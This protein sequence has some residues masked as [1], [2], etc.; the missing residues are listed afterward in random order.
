[1]GTLSFWA[2][3]DGSTANNAALNVENTVTQPTTEITFDSGATGDLHLESNGGLADPDTTVWIDGI[4][5]DFI[6][7]QIGTLPVSPRVPDEYENLEVVVI[8]VVIDGT[9]ERLFFVSDGSGTFAGMEAFGSGA[10][11]LTGVTE[12]PPVVYI[13]FCTGTDIL[14]D[15]GYKKIETLQAGDLVQT[16][17][18]K[19]SPILWIGNSPTTVGEMQRDVTRRPIRIPA[20]AI[21]PGAP[22]ADL[23]VS[24]QH[25]IVL[26][27]CWSQMY[28]GEESVMLPAKHLVGLAAERVMPSEDINY[29]HILLE[30][31][32]VVISNELKTE[33]FQPS[34]RSFNGI[35][36]EMRD[37]LS[38]TIPLDRLRSI[39]RRPDAMRS[40]KRLESNVL[41]ERMFASNQPAPKTISNVG[42]VA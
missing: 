27:G 28:F 39:F 30:D 21:A 26:E 29:Y 20:N 24:A 15:T 32:E 18:G 8:S 17:S 33:S 1:M 41:A 11:A 35:S 6:L 22:N 7:E 31:H 5:Y 13:C 4:E 40:L 14:T 16:E 37:S 23:Y 34:L 12:D 38:E 2:R 9:Y 42:N 10:V 36:Q 25:R 3:G 19:M